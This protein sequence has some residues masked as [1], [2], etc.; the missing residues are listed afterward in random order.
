MELKYNKFYIGL[1]EN[2][3][4]NNFVT[5]KPQRGAIRLEVKLKKSNEIEEKIESS[6]IEV[7]DYDSRWGRYRLKLKQ[8]DIKKYRD[9]L[10]ELFSQA[11]NQ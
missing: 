5:F 4:A 8:G 2:G 1:S 11:Y 7:L 10:I 9:F 3:H 6:G